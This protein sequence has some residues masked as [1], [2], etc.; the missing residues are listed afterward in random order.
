M[1]LQWR[2]ATHS[3]SNGGNCIEVATAPRTVAV[4]DSKD[5]DG[6]RLAFGMQAWKA[7]AAEVKGERSLV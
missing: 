7:F 3:S 4:R 2:K 5:P 1:N 6:P